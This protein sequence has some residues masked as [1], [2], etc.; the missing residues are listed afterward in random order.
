MTEDEIK[1]KILEG[2]SVMH[3][4]VKNGDISDLNMIVGALLQLQQ[5]LN[6]IRGFENAT[7]SSIH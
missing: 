1:N 6:E 5:R 7:T 3:D 4:D 2:V